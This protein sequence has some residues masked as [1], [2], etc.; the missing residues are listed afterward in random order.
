MVKTNSKDKVIALAKELATPV[1]FTK[2]EKA[3]IIKKQ[4][5]W[6]KVKNLK[7][8]PEY[9][10]SQIRSIKID[11]GGNC[12]VQFPKSWKRAQLIYRE[13]MGKEYDE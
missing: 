6:F 12:Y 2:L 13:M 11:S 8:L 1:D 5:A 3:G 9:A 4:G 7:V 10:A